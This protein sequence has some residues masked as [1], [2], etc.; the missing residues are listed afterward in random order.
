MCGGSLTRLG[1]TDGRTLQGCIEQE[2]D[3]PGLVE[4]RNNRVFKTEFLLNLQTIHASLASRLA[5]PMT[6]YPLPS[7]SSSSSFP[8]LFLLFSFLFP[9]IAVSCAYRVVRRS[10]ELGM[11]YAGACALVALYYLV[12]RDVAATKDVFKKIWELQKRLQVVHLAA[13]ASW[14]APE[15]FIKHAAPLVKTLGKIAISKQRAEHLALL[16]KSLPTEIQQMYLKVSVWM[17]RME[18]NLANRAEL[19][20]ILNTRMALL[21]QG[22]A[23]AERLVGIFRETVHFHV[24]LGAPIKRS[25]VRALF[26]AVELVKAIEATLAALN[27]GQTFAGVTV[28]ALVPSSAEVLH[29]LLCVGVSCVSCRVVSY[30]VKLMR[31]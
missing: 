26:Q 2:F 13:N 22:P 28:L 16:D 25:Q 23:L 9:L 10:D 27:I 14:Q 5:N 6:G 21:A 29:P 12:Y 18:S 30:H 17:V 3:F 8:L 15:F 19:R 1:L 24:A 31:A 11:K 20:D 7:S 4:V